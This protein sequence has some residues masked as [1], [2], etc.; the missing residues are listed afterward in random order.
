MRALRGATVT[1]ALGLAAMGVLAASPAH[2][3]AYNG[4]C[5]S[6]YAVVNQIEIGDSGT[7]FLTYNNS[8]G[9][10]CAVTVR[11]T[12][13]D[14]VEMV[15]GLKR[16]PDDASEAVQD[17]GMYTTY[18]GPVYLH[19]AGTCVDWYGFIG[20]DNNHENESNCG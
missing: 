7:T 18:A 6:G 17:A 8:T 12:P 14:P 11:D 20:G 16:T 15:V 1:A 4:A 2:A 5:G 19:A 13:G 10:N 9:Y 3:A